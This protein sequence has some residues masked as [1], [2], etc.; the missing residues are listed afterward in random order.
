MKLTRWVK[1]PIPGR[2]EGEGEW[3]DSAI[4][5]TPGEWDDLRRTGS[6]PTIECVGMPE[7]DSNGDV[8]RPAD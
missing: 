6:L 4:R 2:F 5:M 8:P 1:I 7:P 3:A